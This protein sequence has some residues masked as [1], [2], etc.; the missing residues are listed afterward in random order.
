MRT[1]M[2]LVLAT[3]GLTGCGPLMRGTGRAGFGIALVRLPVTVPLNVVNRRLKPEVRRQLDACEVA[4]SLAGDRQK[5]LQQVR[6]SGR[7]PLLTP[8]RRPEPGFVSQAFQLFGIVPYEYN[9]FRRSEERLDTF[10][11]LR[12]RHTVVM[13]CLSG[14]GARAASLGRHVLGQLE[15][16]YNRVKPRR[17]RHLIDSID[18]YSS[19]S[20]GSIYASHV[21]AQHVTGQKRRADTFSATLTTGLRTRMGTA[22]L[23]FAAALAYLSPGNLLFFPVATL[24]TEFNYLDQ[25]AHAL[26][27]TQGGG[28][29]PRVSGHRLSQLDEA[30]RFYFNAVCHETASLFVLTQSLLHLPSEVPRSRPDDADG[31]PPHRR[32]PFHDVLL[33]ED[34]GSSPGALPLAYAAMASAAFPIGLDPLPVRKYDYVPARGAYRRS[35]TILHLTDG[36]IYDNSGVTT[37]L[38]LFEH[39]VRTTKV[40]RLVLLQVDAEKAEYDLSAVSEVRKPLNWL[41]LLVPENY[42]PIRGLIPAAKSL[43]LMYFVGQRSVRR[44]AWLRLAQLQKEL[45]DVECCHF[46]VRL[47]HLSPRR[48]HPIQGD[49]ELFEALGDI[50]TDYTIGPRQDDLLART[51][52]RLLAAERTEPPKDRRPADLPAARGQAAWPVG[53]G[54]RI[55]RRLDHAFACAIVRAHQANWDD[56]PDWGN[57]LS[58]EA[59]AR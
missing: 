7:N 1:A 54:G 53:P 25:L 29:V 13:V 26:N 36:G 58:P 21:A 8:R 45:P 56:E 24:T 14:G 51:A 18:A 10:D 35:S 55:I 17:G 49:A 5:G 39:L 32:P 11:D 27:I 38:A 52:H 37:A 23:G 48:Q 50:T 33:L 30:P 3:V 57:G 40:R 34:I 19:V 6:A 22:H 42:L 59:P 15:Q 31:A 16:A 9:L 2:A 4:V 28:W 20:G 46:P 44:E 47:R 43:S 41:K 12:D